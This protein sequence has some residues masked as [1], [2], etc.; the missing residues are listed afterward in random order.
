MGIKWNK[1]Y[2]VTG[3]LPLVFVEIYW[4]SDGYVVE[5]NSTVYLTDIPHIDEAKK[6]AEEKLKELLT[7]SLF[8]VSGN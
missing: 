2:S 5:I 4:K 7:K 6:K 3:R 1:G 8:E